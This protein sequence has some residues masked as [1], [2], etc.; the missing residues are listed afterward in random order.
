MN[1]QLLIQGLIE[2]TLSII[3]AFFIFL[4]GF[5]FFDFLTKNINE[6]KELKEN[7]AA[8]GL[9]LACFILG[10]MLI[11][12]S[13]VEPA[14]ETL[15]FMMGQPDFQ[16]GEILIGICR[17]LLFYFIS[18]LLSFLI[19]WATINCFMM[20]T[21]KIDEMKLIK[22]NNYSV[23]LLIGVFIVSISILLINPV[24]MILQ[25]FTPSV[26]TTVETAQVFINVPV[27]AEGIASLV[28]SIM[29]GLL[30][31]FIGFKSLDLL[32]K[33]INE[34]KELKENNLA[35]AI[36]ASSFIFSIMLLIGSAVRPSAST[37]EHITPSGES[38]ATPILY[39][40]IRILIFYC[41]AGVTAFIIIW[42]TLL[43]YMALT[44]KIDEMKQI[45]N[46]NVAVALVMA[47]F[48]LSM[49]LLIEPGFT[50]VLESAIP[51]PSIEQ[52][53]L[54]DVPKF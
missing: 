50:L 10:I 9:I 4:T 23:A 32:T 36:L 6:T 29:G 26:R 25:A 39:S 14:S 3:T 30:V 40:I 7:N 17:I 53:G 8:V 41:A 19:L 37:L 24:T 28:L 15:H 46:K 42:A 33:N 5:K 52:G 18:A 45:K 16:I 1:T 38:I 35:V 34:I 12:R 51:L 27:L 20:M 31:F 47:V 49:A 2:L 13:A 44:G 54:I 22:E 21:R 43:L 48:I 11:V